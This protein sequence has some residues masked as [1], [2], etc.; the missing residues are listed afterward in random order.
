MTL[1][2]LPD[3]KQQTTNNM[4][5]QEQAYIEGFVK[6]ASEYGFNENGALLGVASPLSRLPLGAILGSDKRK[7]KA[8]DIF[9]KHVADQDPE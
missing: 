4:N 6:R 7:D 9:N 2:D 5:T 3:N 8:R 1:G